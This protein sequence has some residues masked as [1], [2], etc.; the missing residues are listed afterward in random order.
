MVLAAECES[1]LQTARDAVSAWAFR[2]R[3]DFGAAPRFVIEEVGGNLQRHM[4]RTRVANRCDQQISR[5]CSLTY[6]SVVIARSTYAGS[7]NSFVRTVCV[8]VLVPG[9]ASAPPRELHDFRLLLSLST[10][11]ATR[12]ARRCEALCGQIVVAPRTRSLN[13]LRYGLPT[14]AGPGS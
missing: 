3:F 9:R 2:F 11:L 14:A 7:R 4:G 8:C 13:E 10:R 5:G 12:L 1:D 6:T